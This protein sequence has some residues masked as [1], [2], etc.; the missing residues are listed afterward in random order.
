VPNLLYIHS[1]YDE[2]SFE[3]VNSL[4]YYISHGP[5]SAPIILEVAGKGNIVKYAP[6]CTPSP[7]HPGLLKW[8]SQLRS[9]GEQ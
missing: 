9:I 3:I 2:V 6:I 5:R 4:E 1:T 8:G 7:T